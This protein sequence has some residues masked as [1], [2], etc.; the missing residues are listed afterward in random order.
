MNRTP[1]RVMGV[2]APAARITRAAATLIA[3]GLAALWGGF[4]A[5]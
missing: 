3:F 4:W 2:S 5:L 1:P